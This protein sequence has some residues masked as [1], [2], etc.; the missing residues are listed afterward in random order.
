ML[1]SKY[2]HTGSRIALAGLFLIGLHGQAVAQEAPEADADGDVIIVTA[3]GR[4]QSLQDV[5]VAV[6][7][8]SGESLL[9]QNIT[10]LQDLSSRVGNVKITVGSLVNSINVRGV[11][12]GENAGFEQA[13]ATFAD[14]VYRS[15]SKSTF[16]AL[17]DVE[18]VELL[19]GPQTTFF[20]ANAS[21]GALSITTRRPDG[22]F[23]YNAS[24][25]YGFSDGE[26]DFQGGVSL[27]V[28]DTLSVRAAGRISGME[29]Y[30]DIEPRETGPNENNQQGRLSLHW[31]PSSSWTTDLRVDLARTR[32]QD[33]FPFQLINCPAVGFPANSPSCNGYLAADPDLDDEADFHSDGDPS[34][35]LEFDFFEVAMT[36]ALDVGFGTIRSISAY[37]DMTVDARVSLVPVPYGA[38]VPG[39]F[40]FP[41]ES[42]ETYEFYSQE[43]RLESE[44][45][46][47]L[48]YMIGAYYS[49]GELG[50][51]GPASFNFL[52]LDFITESA[53]NVDWPNFAAGRVMSG[54]PRLDQTENMYS[55][56]AS[57]TLHPTETI[58]VNLGGRYTRVDKEGHRSLTWGTTVDGVPSTFVPFSNATQLATVGVD[59]M[60][61]PIRVPF[62][63]TQAICIILGC[64]TGDFAT[65][66]RSDD[67]FMPSIGIQFDASDDVMLY[68]TFSKAFKAGGFS[69]TASAVSFGPEQADAYEFGIKSRL[70]DDDLTLNVAVFRMDYSGLQETTFD[71]NLSSSITNV[72]GARSQGIE[73]GA[74]WRF[75]EYITLNADVAYLDATYNDY[76]NGECTKRQIANLP[77][78]TPCVQ[79]LNGAS[80]AYAPDWSGSVGFDINIPTGDYV[81]SLNPSVNFSSSYF[82]TA[83]ADPLF[84]QDSYQKYDLRLAYGPADGPW[85][86]ALIGRNLSNTVT[87]SYRLGVPG[88][89]GSVTSLVERGRSVGIQFVI[90]N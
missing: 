51:G 82:M 23:E 78:R 24:A 2:T 31:E 72:A 34:T 60:G 57:A 6:S 38:I 33:A 47:F 70:L 58:R 43:V 37:S 56:F 16:A 64:N 90:H 27:P 89:D 20:G 42:S 15:R 44:T 5:P 39:V 26:Y 41:V 50:Y 65:T 68:G 74:A 36:N 25:L 66:T 67:K 4:E 69:S 88:A 83:T 54:I 35:F 46:G 59:G 17:F 86:L 32:S 63:R 48:E 11:G 30:V 28:T 14:G 8:V 53:F 3:Q 71:A 7:V 12:S 40:P 49:H 18:R 10:S 55:A 73:V 79:N 19:R 9:E 61:Q 80:R 62:T 29:G 13:V 84:Q 45:G 87:T 1:K 22:D 85:E 21:A 76:T 77:P 81:F 52:P 75:N